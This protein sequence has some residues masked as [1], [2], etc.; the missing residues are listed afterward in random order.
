MRRQYAMNAQRLIAASPGPMDIDTLQQWEH[1]AEP[2]ALPSPGAC[3]G[4]YMSL[5]EQ[6]LEQ[7]R[8]L[9]SPTKPPLVDDGNVAGT[10]CCGV[11]QGASGQPRQRPSSATT[12]A[13]RRSTLERPSSA[14]PPH[15]A[16]GQMQ[17][18][19]EP[20]MISPTRS[21][22]QMQLG[23]SQQLGGDLKTVGVDRVFSLTEGIRSCGG[24]NT[25]GAGTLTEGI[26][27]CG[28]ANTCG[29]GTQ[30][31]AR[32]MATLHQ[33]K[34][35]AA[36]QLVRA[37]LATS[38]AARSRTPRPPKA[39]TQHLETYCSMPSHIPSGS[40]SFCEAAVIRA[41]A[42]HVDDAAA[43][44]QPAASRARAPPAPPVA[45]PP[46]FSA[47][48][49]SP[50]VMSVMLD[51]AMLNEATLNEA[52]ATSLAGA[53]CQ[54][55]SYLSTGAVVPEAKAEA[56]SSAAPS[57]AAPSGTTEKTLALATALE[58]VTAV[59]EMEEAVPR[60][61]QPAQGSSPRMPPRMA[62]GPAG[63]AAGELVAAA[64]PLV[65]VRIPEVAP[66][67]ATSQAG[68]KAALSRA[69]PA[70]FGAPSRAPSRASI[71]PPSSEA[72]GD[73]RDLLAAA[74]ASAVAASGQALFSIAELL[75]PWPVDGR[76]K[77][78]RSTGGGGAAASAAGARAGC[79]AGFPGRGLPTAMADVNAAACAHDRQQMLRRQPHAGVVTRAAF[80]MV[81]SP[82]GAGGSQN[83]GQAQWRRAPRHR[84]A[85]KP[86]AAFVMAADGAR[87]GASSNAH[88]PDAGGAAARAPPAGVTGL[89]AVA[90]RQWGQHPS[91]RGHGR[92]LCVGCMQPASQGATAAAGAFS[93]SPPP[94]TSAPQDAQDGAQPSSSTTAI[95]PAHRSAPSLRSC[96]RRP[97]WERPVQ[98]GAGSPRRASSQASS[99]PSTDHDCRLRIDLT[100]GACGSNSPYGALPRKQAAQ[101]RGAAPMT[102]G[103]GSRARHLA[104]VRLDPTVPS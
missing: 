58:A 67:V 51:E 55:V 72:S 7:L 3:F 24:A 88:W 79:A 76:G 64:P 38:Q 45:P 80:V 57:S 87:Y 2:P 40:Q 75:G 15:A 47:R 11:V 32:H 42:L 13:R 73:Q 8:Y 41:A 19:H 46:P 36:R 97:S 29:A 27:S 17:Q 25:C 10:G 99:P 95:V 53:C 63:L 69:A 1:A 100:L 78:T 71:A 33:S 81:G 20:S 94:Q 23:G 14:P 56:P 90:Y 59:T 49:V 5:R 102:A 4:S 37:A 35:R 61:A 103:I 93:A 92:D 65:H 30:R 101:E 104:G 84:T 85:P 12:D 77:G 83:A 22:M 48:Y 34:M 60:A 39:E 26:R 96:C 82:C 62:L 50:P 74:A 9:Q 44:L 89:A 6:Y 91:Q 18:Q 68:D 54:G 70:Y 21:P 52:S 98:Q 66:E 31:Q 28:G 86:A 43:G 16:S